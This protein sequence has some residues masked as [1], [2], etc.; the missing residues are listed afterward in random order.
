MDDNDT[1]SNFIVDCCL[2]V[3][4]P[5]CPPVRVLTPDFTD[6]QIQYPSTL[7]LP[8]SFNRLYTFIHPYPC[9]SDYAPPH[10]HL[11][12]VAFPSLLFLRV[13]GCSLSPIPVLSLVPVDARML[14]NRNSMNPCNVYD[15]WDGHE[16]R[17]LKMEVLLENKLA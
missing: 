6:R 14:C 16:M 10:S 4:P 1:I 2:F 11:I 5:S 12:F 13:L 15:E 7:S 3:P 8:S 9:I 17:I